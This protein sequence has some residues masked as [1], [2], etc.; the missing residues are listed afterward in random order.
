[1]RRYVSGFLFFFCLTVVSLL[2][3]YCLTRDESYEREQEIEVVETIETPG[4]ALEESQE[5]VMQV[6]LNP[7]QITVN[8]TNKSYCLVVEEGYLIVYDKKEKEVNLFTHMPVTE[9]PIVEQE[10]LLEGIWFPSMAEIFSYLESFS[11]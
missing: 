4:F 2:G 3:L 1:M 11:S 9:F 5:Q 6:V 7:E 10:K 8:T